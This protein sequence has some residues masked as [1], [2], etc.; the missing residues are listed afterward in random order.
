LRFF[1]QPVPAVVSNIA[2]L[3]G[4]LHVGMPRPYI[5]DIIFAGALTY[6]IARRLRDP[7][8]RFVSLFSDYFILLLLLGIALTGLL[9]RFAARPDLIAIKEFGLSLAALHPVALPAASPIFLIHLMLVS[10]LAGYF[11][12]SMLMHMAGA[13]L[14]PT[15]I[16]ANNSR[17]KR[18]VNPWNGPVV[19]RPYVEWE[20][21]FQ[22]KMKAAGI[23]LEAGDA[24][25]AVAD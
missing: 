20:R 13:L 21:E 7:M 12:A 24:G 25:K 10:T 15:R 14:S 5:S 18:H 3:D 6:L 9:M 23:P 1:L 8:L 11:P 22:D 19:T 2:R 16:L 17:A 4:V